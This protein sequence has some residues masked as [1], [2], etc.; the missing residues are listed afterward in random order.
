MVKAGDGHILLR[1][2]ERC[3]LIHHMTKEEAFEKLEHSRFRSSFHLAPGDVSKVRQL[4]EAKL[5]E[6]VT[7]FVR[8]KLADAMPRND[9][10]QTPYRGHP[11]FK[12]MHA[13]AM[14]CRGCMNRWWNVPRN[15]ALSAGQQKKV[16]DFLMVW[17]ARE[18]S[19][20]CGTN[21]TVNRKSWALGAAEG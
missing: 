20:T 14:C 6:H 12:A 3:G 21:R 16:V 15:V 7:D 19:A 18:M 1:R 8:S 17:I 5:R 4:G 11:A 2:G 9:G 10:K 13:C